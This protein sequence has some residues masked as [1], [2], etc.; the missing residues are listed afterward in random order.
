MQAKNLQQLNDVGTNEKFATAESMWF[1]FVSSRRIREGFGAGRE[2]NR[3]PCELI[4]IET[5]VTRLYLCGKLSAPQLEIMQEYGRRR[6]APSQH[7][8]AENRAAG[9]WDAAMRTLDVA[10]R[11]K[12]WVE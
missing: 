5:L 4:D 7:V 2:S 1:W 6:R 12:G 8:W 10:A 11:A 9:L 3:R